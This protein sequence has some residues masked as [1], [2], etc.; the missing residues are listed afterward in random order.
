MPK[1]S[2]GK[3]IYHTELLFKIVS[4]IRTIKIADITELVDG[5]GLNFTLNTPARNYD[6]RAEAEADKLGWME[7]IQKVTPT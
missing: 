4:Y 3:D 2:V 1:G 6:L 7:T 5:E